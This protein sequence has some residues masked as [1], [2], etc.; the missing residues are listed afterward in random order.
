MRITWVSKWKSLP[1]LLATLGAVALIG[2]ACAGAP[3][4]AP[5]QAAAPQAAAP[6]PVAHTPKP[7]LKLGDTQFD[8][9][10]LNNAIAKFIIEKGYGYP[11]DT[12]ETTTPIAE[13]A[14]ARGELDIWLELWQQNWQEVYD[15]Q[16]AAG[17]II[18]VGAIYEAG[19]Q[20][21]I[22]P[23]WVSE[24][25]DIKTIEDLKRPDVVALFKNPENPSKGAF[26]NCVSGW[27]CAQINRAK[28][29]AY[30]LDEYYDII[31]PGSTGAMDA[32]LVGPQKRKQPVFG[33]YWA[34]TALV[35][36]FDWHVIEEPDYS[37]DAWAEVLK[38]VENKDYIPKQA[39]AY[40]TLPVD[41]GVYKGT[42]QKAP[43]VVELLKKMEVG[44]KPINETL[45]WADENNVK[46]NSE[47]I[48]VRYLK[49]YED[50]WTTWMPADK[51]QKVKEALAKAS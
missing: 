28:F 51:V 3:E 22:V 46:P 23:T 8:S 36:M 44:L 27:E 13:V 18:N 26:I 6:Q 20:F 25:H 45:A 4:A 43:D 50:R 35:G 2:T 5:P 33:Y 32:A 37:A 41:I 29:R 1:A 15:R 34:P 42:P 10:W 17:D 19:P 47:E 48:A 30:G 14:L 9:L 21:F 24:Q 12:V 7:T 38:G 11:V 31:E 39:S 49:S 40:E 16:I